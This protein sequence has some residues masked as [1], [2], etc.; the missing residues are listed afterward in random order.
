[1]ASSFEK[2]V[3]GATKIK[4]APPKT[5]YIEH[6]L[7]ATHSGEAGVGEV[8]RALQHRLRDSTWTVVFKSLITVH[9]MIREGS[10]DVTLAYLAKHRNMLAVSMFSDAQTQGRNIRHYAN[11]LSERARSYRETKTDWVRGRDN[12]LEKLSV[13]KGLLRETESVQSQLMAL[14]KCDVMDNEPENEITI[15]V[16]RLLVLDLLALFQVLNHALINILGHFFEMSRV[17]AERAMEVYRGFIKQTDMV[18]Q[19][20]SMARQY[21]HHT[22]VEVPKLKHAPVNLGRQLEDY[23]NDPDFEVHR[24]QY[25]AELAVKKSKG[26]S[27]GGSV[28]AFKSESAS[29]SSK[30][31]PASAFPNVNGAA[32]PVETKATTASKVDADLIDFF[33]SIEQNQTPLGE[34]PT[35][36]PPQIGVSPWGDAA[37]QTQPTAQF[38]N[39]FMPQQ[40]GF[41][42]TNPFQQQMTGFPQPQPQQQQ[43]QLQAP[44]GGGGFMSQSGFQSSLAPIPQDSVASFQTGTASM[45]NLQAQ[46]PTTNPFRASMLMAANQNPMM[47]GMSAQTA[48]PAAAPLQPQQTSTNPFAR[49][50]SQSNPPPF[51]PSQP[52]QAAAAAPMLPMATGTNPFAKNFGAGGNGAAAAGPQLQQRPAT[53]AGLAPQPTGTTN[54]FRQSQFVN[55]NTGMGWQHNQQPMGGGL[56]GLQTVSVFPRPASQSPWQQ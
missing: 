31:V 19:Y 41:Q 54:P 48:P 53:S 24:R 45:P 52:Q 32:S 11:Y 46:Q 17:D 25:L 55:H 9:L 5:K 21:E 43:Q 37:F 38:T 35:T 6:I 47:T 12:R 28:P 13:E 20:L 34:A 8:F 16:F 7:V 36:Q 23:L 50:A 51:Q 4:A 39:G 18:V 49:P 14:L 3:K 26:G 15:T 40:T 42:T 56:D 44:Y 30:P 22:R 33:D 27:S 1:M 2:S 29:S 10:P